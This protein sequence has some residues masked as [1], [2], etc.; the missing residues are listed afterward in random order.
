MT[1]EES[2]EKRPVEFLGNDFGRA[3]LPP[4]WCVFTMMELHL[5]E[6]TRVGEDERASALIQDQVIVLLR[7]KISGGSL[8]SSA[9]PKMEAKPILVRKAK[10]HSLAARFRTQQIRSSQLAAQSTRVGPA[11]DAFPRVQA[12]PSNLVPDAGVPPAPK[13][14][15][16]RQ[17][18]HGR[19]LNAPHP[20]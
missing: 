4:G 18:R 5:P 14:F 6:L 12:G 17:L 3:I 16:L 10:E 20:Y 11:K 15:Y 1:F 9:H 7:M 19:N 13:I 8:H 2:V